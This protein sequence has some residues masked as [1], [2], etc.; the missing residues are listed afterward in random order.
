LFRIVQS[1]P[2]KAAE[3]FKRWLAKT[4]YERIQEI[5]NPEI[6]IKRAMLGYKA[7]GRSDEW[8]HAR[9]QTIASRK[10]LVRE[11]AKRGVKEGLEYA[12]LTDVIS[13]GTFG[14]GVQEHKG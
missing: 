11:W 1:I 7:Q 14:L 10:E 3:P 4:G 13:K 9:I 8:I 2:S 5:Q 12:I 6:A